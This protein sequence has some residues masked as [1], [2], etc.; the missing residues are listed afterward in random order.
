[1]AA[2]S[3][4]E[5]GTCLWVNWGLELRLSEIHA[6][7]PSPGLPG[8]DPLS[9]RVP[10]HLASGPGEIPPVLCVRFE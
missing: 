5:S 1:M 8:V 3:A 2:P 4:A 9:V 6:A 7:D 10:T